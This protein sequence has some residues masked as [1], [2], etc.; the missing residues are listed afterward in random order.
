[1]QVSLEV[2][3]RSPRSVCSVLRYR[4]RHVTSDTAAAFHPS[5]LCIRLSHGTE[6]SHGDPAVDFSKTLTDATDAA[7]EAAQEGWV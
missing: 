7:L 3:S 5:V 4:V 1:M 2:Q 6:R